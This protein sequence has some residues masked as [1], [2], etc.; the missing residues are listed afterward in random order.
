MKFPID[1][2]VLKS[3]YLALKEATKRVNAIQ[4]CGI[5]LSQL[6]HIFEKRLRL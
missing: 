1:D 2:E 4:N 5:F 6:I 3:L